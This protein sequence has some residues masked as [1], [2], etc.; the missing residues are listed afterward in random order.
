MK[1]VEDKI[2]ARLKAIGLAPTNA[3]AS[4]ANQPALPASQAP[5]IIEFPFF[6]RLRTASD[7]S[8]PVLLT[9]PAAT[10]KTTAITVLAEQRG[11][12][13]HIQQCHRGLTV[14]EVRG[15]RGLNEAGTTFEPGPLVCSLFDPKGWYFLDEINMADPGILSLLNNLMDGTG[16]LTIPETGQVIARRPSW[17]FFG[18]LN[19][20]Y[21]ATSELNQALRS[22]CVVIECDFL[23]AETEATL[24]AEKYPSMAKQ[25]PVIVKMAAA[26]RAS[27]R[28]GE[29]EFDMC[30]RTCF[31]LAEV[32]QDGL[33]PLDAFREVVL[34]KIGDEATY[35]PVREGLLRAVEVITCSRRRQR[36][37]R[38]R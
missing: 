28:N 24:I 33:E 15:T 18:A 30:L 7:R 20:G 14:E 29:H 38:R 5:R 19:P 27:R 13:V 32:W 6:N 2:Q 12:V 3:R 4:G 16:K 26:V 10:G 36:T 22:R 25:A 1:A 8:W 21:V 9:G 17:R 23:P 34:P 31:Q 11:A 35:G 37:E